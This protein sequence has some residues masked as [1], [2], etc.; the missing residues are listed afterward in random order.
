MTGAGTGPALTCAV[1]E[2][3][4]PPAFDVTS[5]AWATGSSATLAELPQPLA[6]IAS[7]IARR[8][9]KMSPVAA[10]KRILDPGIGALAGVL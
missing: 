5:A 7:A 2:M 10:R 4:A 9:G 1:S 3:C 8:T 6:V